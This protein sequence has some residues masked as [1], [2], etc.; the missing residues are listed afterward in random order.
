MIFVVYLYEQAQTTCMRIAQVH[1]AVCSE[2][3]NHYFLTSLVFICRI[4]SKLFF[5]FINILGF[6]KGRGLSRGFP[7][8][9]VEHIIKEESQCHSLTYNYYFSF[10]LQSFLLPLLLFSRSHVQKKAIPPVCDTTINKDKQTNKQITNSEFTESERESPQSVLRQRV[11]TQSNIFFYQI[12]TP[13]N[14]LQSTG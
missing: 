14:L 9:G 4:R 12:V 1:F 6:P 13:L 3:N 5:Y 2:H 8:V 11:E 7:C 10:L